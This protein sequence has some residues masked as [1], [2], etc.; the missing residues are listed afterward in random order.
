[1]NSASD[2]L[3]GSQ[4]LIRRTVA[5]IFLTSLFSLLLYVLGSVSE[6][7]DGNLLLLLS[8]AG[9]SSAA[10]LLSIGI[11][12]LIVLFALLSR[13]KVFWKYFFLD[14]A[15]GSLSALILFVVSFVRVLEAGLAF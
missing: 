12:F 5:V 9:F 13:K 4:T 15:F 10:V 8:V 1:M 14:M 7:T 11:H 2:I 3:S 6:F